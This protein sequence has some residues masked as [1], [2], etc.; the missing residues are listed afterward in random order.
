MK[1]QNYIV[2]GNQIWNIVDEHFRISKTIEDKI[3]SKADMFNNLILQHFPELTQ[4]DIDSI[5][6]SI[7][8][9]VNKDK[10]AVIDNSQIII[11]LQQENITLKAENTTLTT[12]INNLL[13]NVN[14][15]QNQ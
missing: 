9:E 8:G 13:L 14:Q 4:N 15:Y 12:N 10:Q 7:A 5:R 2:L 3:K 1:N 6:Q 11:Q